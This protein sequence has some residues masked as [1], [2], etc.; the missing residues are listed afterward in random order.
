M[1][2]DR[3]FSATTGIVFRPAIVAVKALK[4]K[5]SRWPL[6]WFGLWHMLSTRIL[7]KHARLKPIFQ[8]HVKQRLVCG[9][10]GLA[11]IC[12][13][14]GVSAHAFA[15]HWKPF[16]SVGSDICF[17][18]NGWTLAQTVAEPAGCTI[19]RLVA[20][21][22]IRCCFPKWRQILDQHLGLKKVLADAC[23]SDMS[24]HFPDCTFLFCRYLVARDPSFCERHTVYEYW[25]SLFDI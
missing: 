4:P 5:S 22:R 12:P 6:D 7:Y 14:D 10:P 15:N 25:Y 8:T 11:N 17:L 20:S 24:I 23:C 2:M 1:R 18:A 21:R 13:P 16:S 19:W 9:L 3:I